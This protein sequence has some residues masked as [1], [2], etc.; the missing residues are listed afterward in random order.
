VNFDKHSKPTRRAKFLAAMDQVVRAPWKLV[1]QR[2]ETANQPHELHAEVVVD[3]G[4]LFPCPDC[5]D[6]TEAREGE[7]L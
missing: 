2:L 1:G 3:R 4:A 5:S 7:A 6:S